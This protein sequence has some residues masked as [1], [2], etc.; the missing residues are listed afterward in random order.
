MDL[1]VDQTDPTEHEADS[2]QGRSRQQDHEI[3]VRKI[4]HDPSIGRRHRKTQKH[5][6][7]YKI[8]K[9]IRNRAKKENFM[10]AHAG[11]IELLQRTLHRLL[12]N[13]G[14]RVL[15]GKQGAH[16]QNISDQH[17]VQGVSGYSRASDGF[18]SPE[19]PHENDE[20]HPDTHDGIEEIS[21]H[22]PPGHSNFRNKEIKRPH[23]SPPGSS[24]G[25]YRAETHQVPIK[26]FD[27]LH[28]GKQIRQ[29]R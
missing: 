25:I 15:H 21:L 9:S 17:A 22:G 8:E 4:H 24:Q 20:H 7:E 6:D 3:H 12:G 1:L 11:E 13:F 10:G 2:H 27:R 18:D 16:P 28:H 23:R 26:T 5:R 14:T 19:H 29:G